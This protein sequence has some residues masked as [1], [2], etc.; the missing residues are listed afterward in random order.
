MK[1]Y[2]DPN[3]ISEDTHNYYVNEVNEYQP[4]IKWPDNLFRALHDYHVS[5]HYTP[6]YRPQRAE[7]EEYMKDR[8]LGI[9]RD[10][11]DFWVQTKK[12]NG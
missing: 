10:Y 2:I 7:L 9:V 5:K 11:D 12:M 8:D 1:E 6:T 4:L 3:P